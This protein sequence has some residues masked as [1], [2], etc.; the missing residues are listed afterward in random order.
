MTHWIELFGATLRL[1]PSPRRRLAHS[2]PNIAAALLLVFAL[3]PL[4]AQEPS[5]VRNAPEAELTVEGASSFGNIHLFAAG[6]DRRIN[7]IGFEY[8]RHSWGGLL[9]A[10][11]D[12]VAELLPVVLLNEPAKYDIY[13]RAL[14]NARQTQYGAGI[15]PIGVRLLWRRHSAFKPYLIGKGGIVYFQNRV[16]SSQG[17]H[18]NFTAQF[19]AGVEQTLSPRFQLRLGVGDFHMSNGDIVAHNPG[20]DMMTVGAGLSYRFGQ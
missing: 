2:L 15:S 14:T 6:D 9:T 16:L 5:P 18:L 20:I 1:L 4:R 12:Y 7:P 3:P 19:G 13:G 11:V 8:D 10:R 17:S